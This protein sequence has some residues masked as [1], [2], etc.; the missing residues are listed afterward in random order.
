MTIRL[1]K[2]FKRLQGYQDNANKLTITDLQT[3]WLFPT[4]DK[5]HLEISFTKLNLRNYVLT[6]DVVFTSNRIT[7]LLNDC[8][9]GLPK[10]LNQ[11]II[12]YLPKNETIQINFSLTYPERYPF[13]APDWKLLSVE[14]NSSFTI[15]LPDYY[16]YLVEVRNEKYSRQGTW[17]SAI[18][19]EKDIFEFM[20]H[21]NH[22]DYLLG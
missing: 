5:Y 21:I 17:R 14:T 4:H 16:K 20:V 8:Y 22:F 9:L 10:V 15:G 1:T 12:S 3:K 19:M 6:V 11:Y 7:Q 2:E 18:T 13:M